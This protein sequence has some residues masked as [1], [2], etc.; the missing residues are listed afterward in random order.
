[1]ITFSEIRWIDV[2]II[3]KMF[4]DSLCENSKGYEYYSSASVPTN[5]TV[6]T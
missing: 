5:N 2:N 6:E 4:M 3:V 1:M